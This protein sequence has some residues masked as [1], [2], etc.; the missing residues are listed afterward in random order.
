MGVLVA[1]PSLRLSGIYFALAT[2]AFATAMDAWVF[3]LPAFNLFGTQFAPFGTGSL[4]FAP[5]RIG[6]LAI[7]SKQ[8]QFVV[9]SVIFMILVAV[10]VLIRRSEFGSQL[11]AFK[12]S[13]A[14][15]ATLG[16]NTRVLPIAVF[17][18]SA[19]IAGI[20]GAVYGQAL[21][22]TAPDIFQ[23]FGG[24]TVLLT[25]VIFGLGSVG[26]GVGTGIF[27][28][29]P[30]LANFFPSLLQLQSILVGGTAVGVGTSPNGLIPSGLRPIWASVARRRVLLLGILAVVA[31]LWA[32]A[33]SGVIDNWTLVWCVV[34]VMVVGPVAPY[35][36]D[37]RGGAA[38]PAFGL[39]EKRT[40]SVPTASP[41]TPI[42]IPSPVNASTVSSFGTEP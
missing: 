40:A 14:A 10:V 12:D 38:A 15:C 24:L 11:F 32:L 34:V 36:I 28:G 41:L 33:Y 9:G 35:I 26:G 8:A 3:P 30:T 37:Y 13:P 22:S 4:T 23:F 25:M 21:G 5:F 2:A 16:M 42:D 1:L 17:A 18:I 20:G 19:A 39:P 7:Q 6:G 27:L 29:G 31:G